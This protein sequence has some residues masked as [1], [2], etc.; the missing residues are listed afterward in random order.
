MEAG[1]CLKALTINPAWAYREESRR[2]S[3]EVGK[4]ADFT[5]LSTNPLT[6]PTAR[7]RSIKVVGTMKEGRFAWEAEK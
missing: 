2:G 5:V 6:T 1:G 3:I 7:I 4:L